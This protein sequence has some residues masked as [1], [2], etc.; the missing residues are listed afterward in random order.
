MMESNQELGVVNSRIDHLF[1]QLLPVC[2]Y[3]LTPRPGSQLVQT[4]RH[5]WEQISLPFDKWEKGKGLQYMTMLPG[6]HDR[7][8]TFV[9]GQWL[10]ERPS[11]MPTCANKVEAS[12]KN[13]ITLSDYGKSQ[14]K[15]PE[16]PAQTVALES[17]KANVDQVPVDRSESA[18][19]DGKL[20]NHSDQAVTKH[21]ITN[22]GYV[23]RKPHRYGHLLIT[24]QTPRK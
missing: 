20:P 2:P 12:L 14:S 11:V 10:E 9:E 21:D 1:D 19:K 13:K 23:Y 5:I 15:T 16:R 6:T 8:I 22:D 7:G 4:N 24:S 17:L 3:I 18:G